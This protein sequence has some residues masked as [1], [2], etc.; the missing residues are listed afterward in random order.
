M[1]LPVMI[2]I[3][4]VSVIATLTGLL[5]GVLSIVV[6]VLNRKRFSEI[7]ILYK[8]K[9]GSLPDAVLLF[10]NVN[11]LYINIAYST[12]VQFIYIP[13]L[14]N[15]SSILTKNDDKD[16]IRGLPKRLIGPFYVEIFLAV[17]SLIFFIIGGLLMVA[18]ERGWV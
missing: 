3:K 11:T 1:R 10:E 17:V 5:L 16:F 9:Y 7:C 14:W 8:K 6:S 18:I 2:S 13:L 15:R 12:K 4:M